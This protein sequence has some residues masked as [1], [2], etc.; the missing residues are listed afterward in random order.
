M[1]RLT[2]TGKIFLGVLV[3]MHLA[4]ITSQSGLLIWL[5]GLIAGCLA[6]NAFAAMRAVRKVGLVVPARILV[7]KGSAPREPWRLV[8][9]GR[10]PARLVTV[11]FEGRVWL[12]AA[13][14]PPGSSISVNPRGA[15]HRRGAYP[16]GGAWLVSLYPFGLVKAMRAVDSEAEVLVFPPRFAVAPPRVRGLDP[17]MGGRQ[18]GVGRVAAGEK[19]AGI[20]NFQDGDSL[21]QIHWKS[22]AR[23][24]GLMVKTFEEE[25]AGRAAMLTYCAP[26]SP[27]FEAC[28]RAAGSLARSGIEAGH[29]IEF[30]NLNE[31]GS[32][33]IPPFGDETLLLEALARF[34]PGDHPTPIWPGRLPMRGALHFVLTSLE[35]PFGDRIDS[36]LSGRQVV[37]LHLPEG[38]TARAPCPIHYYPVA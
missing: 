25:L 29:Q 18:T 31:G 8:N 20:R 37:V 1:L 27:H 2:R 19:F 15:F 33:R 35:A 38:S 32:V 6:V 14:V 22:S 16:L 24:G 34:A 26:G 11:E 5:V 4:S 17:M 21:R 30:H 28:L 12:Q 9:G 10:N 36:L 3:L 23:G 13:E 7:E